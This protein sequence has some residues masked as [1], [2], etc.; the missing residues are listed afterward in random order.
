MKKKFRNKSSKKRRKTK[1]HTSDS[2]HLPY[3]CVGVT[4]CV[5]VCCLCDNYFETKGNITFIYNSLKLALTFLSISLSLSAVL[6]MCLST[7]RFHLTWHLLARYCDLPGFLLLHFWRWQLPGAPARRWT[8]TGRRA[9]LVRHRGRSWPGTAV[10][11]G[12]C[13]Q[14]WWRHRFGSVPVGHAVLGAGSTAPHRT[15]S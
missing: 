12:C 15:V 10:P 2:L 11:A 3:S 13:H 14:W 1:L 5:C 8:R 7:Q 9:L 6:Y 4:M